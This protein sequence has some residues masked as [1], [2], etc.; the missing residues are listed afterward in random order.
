VKLATSKTQPENQLTAG[1]AFYAIVLCMLFGANPVA[2]KISLTGVGAFTT[3]ALRF[4]VAA[5]V[6]TC[7]AIFTG[8][9]L[10]ISKKQ[11]IQMTFMGM[12]FFLQ[13]GIFYFGQN[14]TTASHGVLISNIMPFLV[15]VLAHYLL[16]DDRIN[17][18]KVAGL[19]FGF[20]GIVLLF[21]DSL[22]LT[23]DA[24]TGDLLL[25]M[26][27][28]IW[29]CNAIFVKRIIAGFTP[30]Q[31]TLYPMLISIPLFYLA[32]MLLDP[33]MVFDLSPSVLLGMF[34]QSIV[35]ASFGFVMWNGLMQKYGATTLHA[36]VFVM[37]L[38]GVLLGVVILGEALTPN[39]A[40]SIFM[41]AMGLIVI[42][43]RRR[44]T[45]GIQF[46]AIR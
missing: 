40:G 11:F 37:P 26:A 24:I 28:I 16:P 25:V 31:I 3:G 27:V 9:K 34:Y 38:S 8:R 1:A 13:I 20:S 23:Q 39:L 41:V 35:T 14:K 18:R 33:R 4:S 2:A 44:K 29:S 19:I 21:R 17:P 5:T 7:W 32:G 22:S 43:W 30:L 46:N 15:M 42:N 10:A 6:L 45:T 36:F 12:L